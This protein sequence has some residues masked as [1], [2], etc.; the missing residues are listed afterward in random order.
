MSSSIAT[1]LNK[2]FENRCSQLTPLVDAF[3]AD[4]AEHLQHERRFFKDHIYRPLLARAPQGVRVPA[5]DEV[6]ESFLSVVARTVAEHP[7][8]FIQHE[9]KRPFMPALLSIHHLKSDPSRMESLVWITENAFVDIVEPRPLSGVKLAVNVLHGIK[10]AAK[11]AREHN[12]Q[13]TIRELALTL[14]NAF[15]YQSMR[16]I[17]PRD[18]MSPLQLRDKRKR[19]IKESYLAQLDNVWRVHQLG[20]TLTQRDKRDPRCRRTESGRGKPISRLTWLHVVRSEIGRA[21]PQHVNTAAKA[22]GQLLRL[23]LDQREL[24]EDMGA[25]IFER[26]RWLRKPFAIN[27]A[28]ITGRLRQSL[29]EAVSDPSAGHIYAEANARVAVHRKRLKRMRLSGTTMRVYEP[30]LPISGLIQGALEQEGQTTPPSLYDLHVHLTKIGV[31][32]A[33]TRNL[34]KQLYPL[35]IANCPRRFHD[36]CLDF[37]PAFTRWAL[38]MPEAQGR[39]RLYTQVFQML[40]SHLAGGDFDVYILEDLYTLADA[41]PSLN[42]GRYKSLKQLVADLNR[43]NVA[44]E[45]ALS[46]AK[47]LGFAVDKEDIELCANMRLARALGR[48]MLRAPAIPP[49]APE[50]IRQQVGELSVSILPY[51]HLK[52]F[53]GS[54]VPGVCIQ[55][56]SAYHRQHI[57]PECRN[58]IVHD[59]ERIYLWGLLVESST[60]GQYYLNNFQGALPSRLRKYTDDIVTG[61][62][63]VLREL[64]TVYLLDFT[65]NSISLCDD[66]PVARNVTLK[67]PSMRLDLRQKADGTLEQSDF[68]LVDGKDRG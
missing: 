50:K 32:A 35:D 59:S 62:H 52:G 15:D 31:T 28:E 55:F 25:A 23:H 48:F 5:A 30:C 46:S 14:L 56:G 27:P 8:H 19:D 51:T 4:A 37:Y 41:S 26:I 54:G 10:D 3:V 64:G 12:D 63:Q 58:L 60:R 45:Q 16:F 67:L 53:L 38:S 2:R 57:R 33:A 7:Q 17:Q 42:D 43:N 36:H 29:Q 9:Y 40:T 34:I 6:T 44:L 49:E 20:K 39:E 66:L 61:V 22:Q 13:F 68:Y 18:W 24:L 1:T 21:L 11:P 65:F 47:M